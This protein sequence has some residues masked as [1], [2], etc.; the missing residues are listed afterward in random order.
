MFI[1][2]YACASL[3]VA[4]L[5]LAALLARLPGEARWGGVRRQL[6]F[7]VVWGAIFPMLGLVVF[8]I[9]SAVAGA[10][11]IG[12]AQSFRLPGSYVDAGPLGWITLA[13]A[14]VGVLSP[15]LAAFLA[16]R[17][18]GEETAPRAE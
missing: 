2:A 1:G 9:L 13:V 10:I 15:V 5:S 8:L 6:R 11:R 14:V 3:G 7:F 16:A 12:Q 4:G 17:R 18:R